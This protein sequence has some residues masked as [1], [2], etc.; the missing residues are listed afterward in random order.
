MLELLLFIAVIIIVVVAIKLGRQDNAPAAHPVE[1][2]KSTDQVLVDANRMLLLM[3]VMRQAKEHNDTATVQAVNKMTYDG[4]LPELLPDGSYT[5]LYEEELSFNIAGI[6]Y[7]EGI[8][9]YVGKFDGYLQPDTQNE[10]DP[11][12]IAVYHSDGHHLGF[13][14]AYETQ[15][16]RELNLPFPIEVTGVIEQKHDDSENRDYFQGVV[17]VDVK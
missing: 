12:A 2:T 11:N 8:A 3:E 17:Y 5:S 10:Y 7:R 14:P 16:V 13:I 6:N 9:A 15:E 4:P 1:Q